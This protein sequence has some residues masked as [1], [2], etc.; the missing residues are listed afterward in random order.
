MHTD[1]TMKIKDSIYLF[2]DPHK[3]LDFPLRVK[4]KEGGKKIKISAPNTV[5]STL[6]K[7]QYSK[8]KWH[9]NN[10]H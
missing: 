4:K 10:V 9:S 3:I 5:T 1:G 7:K 2:I 6:I 8:Q